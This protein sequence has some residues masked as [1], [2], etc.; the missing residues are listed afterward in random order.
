L[1]RTIGCRALGLKQLNGYCAV[2]GIEEEG[3][4]NS[5]RKMNYREHTRRGGETYRENE[6]KKKKGKVALLWDLELISSQRVKKG[7]RDYLGN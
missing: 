6:S 7:Q 1:W 3:R 5:L 2:G 4:A